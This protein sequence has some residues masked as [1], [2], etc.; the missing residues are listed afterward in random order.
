MPDLVQSLQNHDLGH[1]RI[2]AEL[3]GVDLTS[4]DAGAAVKELAGALLD[5]GLVREVV[6]SLPSNAR[7]ALEALKDEGGKILWT[8]FARRFGE[9]REAGPGRRDREQIYRQPVS[10]A[11]MLYYRA[12]LARAFFDTPSG[13]QEFAYL[14]EDLLN[15]INRGEINTSP[16]ASH[17]PEAGEPLGR[18][19]LPK[20]RQHPISA[21]DRLLDDATTLLAA[22]RMEIAPP[23]TTIPVDIVAAFLRIAGLLTGQTPQ[24]EAVRRFLESPRPQALTMLAEAWRASK[25]F[26]ELRMLPGL[27]CEGEWANH[28]EVTRAFAL[29]LLAKVPPGKWWSLTA[30][31]REIK[32][33]YPDF[34]RPAGDYDS[35]FIRR[36]ADGAYLRG[37]AAW[38]DVDGALVR[39]LVSGPL[40]WLGMVELASAEDAGPVTA[41]KRVDAGSVKKEGAKLTVTSSGGISVPRLVPRPARYQI[42]RFCDWEDEKPDDYRYRVTTDSLKRAIQQGL[43]VSQ[44]L[45]LLARNA[46]AD[47]PPAFVKALK[48]WELHGTEARVETQTVLRVSRPDVLTELRKSKAGRFLGEAL[49]PATVIIKPG[50]Q[51]KIL[52]ALTEMGLLAEMITEGEE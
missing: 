41:F 21:C 51:A 33:K 7:A 17:S 30:F 2:V 47:I 15:L 11:E 5:P 20:E 32:E 52:A 39:Y 3:W 22:L 19:A 14:P 49:G 45:T 25:T 37:F 42:A 29:D 24:A 27:V 10:A 18:P 50:A 6:E 43:K 35:W 13:A 23:L 44:L 16:S 40:F 8:Q 34:Q 4:P 38:E 48:R 9:I 26:N 12:F 28:P 36:A 1:L 31:V 46:A